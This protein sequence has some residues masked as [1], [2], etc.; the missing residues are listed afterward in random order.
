[1]IGI[2]KAILPHADPD[3]TLVDIDI[4]E[5]YVAEPSKLLKKYYPRPNSHPRPLANIFSD[6]KH[7]SSD[8]NV[9]GYLVKAKAGKGRIE[10]KENLW[11]QWQCIA[12][13]YFFKHTTNERI[14][15]LFQGHT[16][17][18]LL[19]S[20]IL[21]VPAH[22]RNIQPNLLIHK[23]TIVEMWNHCNNRQDLLD[24]DY[25]QPRIAERFARP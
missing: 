3:K 19:V 11:W 2:W 25:F 14:V 10:E 18:L 6:N 1:M 9:K 7:I 20:W 13:L 23:K 5:E 17:K 24:V 4:V 22:I 12:I 15:S 21:S 16:P 8:H